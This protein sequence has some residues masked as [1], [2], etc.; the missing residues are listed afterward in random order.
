MHFFWYALM[1]TGLSTFV[2]CNKPQNSGPVNPSRGNGA[3][4]SLRVE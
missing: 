4:T 1:A 3:I 2:V